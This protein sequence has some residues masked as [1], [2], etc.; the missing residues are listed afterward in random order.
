MGNRETPAI[1]SILVLEDL[2]MT[3]YLP[4]VAVIIAGDSITTAAASIAIAVAVALAALVAAMRVG[5]H[6][7]RALSTRSDEALLLGV[8]GI[9][10]LAAGLAQEAEVSAAIGAFLV[11]IALSGTVQR[12]ASALIG[13]RRAVLRAVRPEDRPR[14]VAADARCCRRARSGHERD[15]DRHGLAGGEGARGRRPRAGPRRD[16]ADRPR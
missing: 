8:L 6:L 14:L 3:V 2:A 7:T 11:G 5:G 1:L 9:T 12:R 15:E 4:V 16:R 13:P 10:L